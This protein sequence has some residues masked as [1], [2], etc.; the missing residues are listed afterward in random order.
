MGSAERISD[1]M[2]AAMKSGDKLSLSVLR[3]LKSDSKYKQI[4]LGRELTEDDYKAVFSSAAKKRRDAIDG[5]EKG[6][7]ADLVA[8]EKAELEIINRYL[9][10]QLSESELEKII[11]DAV[12]ETKASTPND[13][14]LVM[15]NLMPKVKGLADGR[16]VNEL[17]LKKLNG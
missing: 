5:F 6:G 12:A 15:K 11:A 8:K 4:E 9:P 14:G 10:K 16:K 2:K 7:R 13:I 17:V 3:M 1:E